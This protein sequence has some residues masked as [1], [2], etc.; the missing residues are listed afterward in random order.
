M[1]A[2]E[3]SVQPD[4]DKPIDVPQPHP[5]QGLAAADDHLGD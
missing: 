4:E 3:E 5:R 2:R 1:F